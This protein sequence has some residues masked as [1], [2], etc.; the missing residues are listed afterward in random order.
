MQV[1]PPNG[2][3]PADGD[4]GETTACK[5]PVQLEKFACHGGLTASRCCC[6]LTTAGMSNYD[7]QMLTDINLCW[8]N[9]VLRFVTIHLRT[10]PHNVKLLVT[11]RSNSVPGGE[12]DYLE[13]M[14][15]SFGVHS[16]TVRTS[17]AR[18]AR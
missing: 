15:E 1:G 4:R 10:L 5:D 8:E 14:L 17:I 7:D 6:S 16:M 13:H 11:S 2:C 3:A 18:R 12:P 9:P